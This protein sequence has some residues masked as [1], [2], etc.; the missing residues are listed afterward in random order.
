MKLWSV[1]MAAAMVAGCAQAPVEEEAPMSEMAQRRAQFVQKTL[2]ADLGHLGDGDRT[3]LAHLVEAADAMQEIFELQAWADRQAMDEEIAALDGPDAT[4]VQDYYRIMVG[5]W[6]RLDGFEP[7]FGDIQRPEGAGYYP[8]D[9][10][11]QE[12]EAWIG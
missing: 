3:A 6:D 9:M 1:V 10:T 8:A 7:F 4:A 5:P 2:T 12:F 11:A